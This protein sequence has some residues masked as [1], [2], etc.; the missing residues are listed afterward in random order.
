MAECELECPQISHSLLSLEAAGLLIF[1]GDQSPP[2]CATG[3]SP[4]TMA[5]P[6]PSSSHLVDDHTVDDTLDSFTQ[7]VDQT[8]EISEDD[9]L[10]LAEP[11]PDL[12][13]EANGDGLTEDKEYDTRPI[14]SLGSEVA[15]KLRKT[16]STCFRGWLICPPL[17]LKLLLTRSIVKKLMNRLVY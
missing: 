16:V 17:A 10:D 9:F 5:A 13:E 14:S 11:L 3:A 7:S 2:V 15:P 6:R 12:E 1:A 4:L 8:S